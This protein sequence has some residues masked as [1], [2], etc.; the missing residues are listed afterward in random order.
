[1]RAEGLRP[2]DFEQDYG[3][4]AMASAPRA[5]ARATLASLR[6]QI[7]TIEKAAPARACGSAG[8]SGEREAERSA[9][10]VSGAQAFDREIGGGIALAGLT[11]IHALQA[12]DAGLCA[13][14][15]T[16]L[17]SLGAAPAFLRRDPVLWIGAPGVFSEAGVP[18]G[19]GLG[20]LGLGS[21]RL[22]LVEPR[23]LADALWVAEEAAR[24][25]G[26]AATVLEMRGNARDFGL[27]ETQRL[28]RRA[29][30][31][32][33]PLF[34]LRQSAAVEASAAPL[35]LV[36]EPAPSAPLLVLAG[37]AHARAVPGG[38]GPPGFSVT[39]EKNK[40]GPAG[41]T[42]FL[43]WNSHERSF[44]AEQSRPRRD[45]PDAGAAVAGTVVR[46]P[47]AQFQSDHFPDDLAG[48]AHSGADL[49][50]SFDG[51]D[52]ARPSRQDVAADGG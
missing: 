1:M 18:H 42:H 20:G 37:T 24:T 26:L 12:R 48:P 17:L 33:R 27:R 47:S 43:H 44:S 11:E 51:P 13:G 7:A 16:G 28:Q 40:A 4:K 36:V 19:R 34:L 29:Q 8:W 30:S 32:G 22:L 5:T 38:I 15:A 10:L 45:K 2:A 41:R 6:R 46:F 35:R 25:R 50:L 21:N 14:L 39:I 3:T 31:S 9:L 23:T 49:S 52:R